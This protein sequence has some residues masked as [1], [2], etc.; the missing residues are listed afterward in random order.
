V[1]LGGLDLE[2]WLVA[3]FLGAA[4]T[5]P[6]V[7]LIPAFGGPTLPTSVRLGLGLALSALCL[8]FTVALAPASAG[9]ILWIA[10]LGREIVVGAVVGFVVGCFFK[11]AE[12][13]GRL[14]DVLRGANMAEVLA[15]MSE[16][17]SSPLGEIFLLLAV[18]LFSA[19]GGLGH[20][21]LALE[22]SYEAV[23]L[24]PLDPS[25]TL[26]AA[27][28]LVIWS[29]GKLLTA[30]VALAAPAVVAFL[31]TDVILAGVARMAPQIPIFFVGM[32]LKALLGVGVVLV[33]LGGLATALEARH[34]EVLA[35]MAR[36][37][38]LWK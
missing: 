31:L 11:A 16:G 24:R 20:V 5:V 29:S 1:E 21:A 12:A 23:P 32:P 9:P 38:A 22:R 19:G 13:A 33:S 7:F 3:L 34:G 10:L 37:F 4:R 30:G 35:A 28:K 17:R 18:V 26:A 14:T 15:P 2:R 36:A 27:A 8:P 25:G 6:I